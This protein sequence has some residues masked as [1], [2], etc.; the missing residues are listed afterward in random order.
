MFHDQLLSHYRR[1]VKGL[2]RFF[3]VFIDRNKYCIRLISNQIQFRQMSGLFLLICDIC[4][5]SWSTSL[6]IHA[7]FAVH[8][9]NHKII[10]C[11]ILT[12]CLV[13]T[14]IYTPPGLQLTEYQETFAYTSMLHF[15]ICV[16]Y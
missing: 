16:Y 5:F 12:G 8:V 14:T 9:L 13:R 1:L 10:P 2:L 4:C 6:I 11:C 15:N 7:R 3:F